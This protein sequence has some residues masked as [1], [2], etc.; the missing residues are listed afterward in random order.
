MINLDNISSAQK[1]NTEKNNPNARTTKAPLNPP[2]VSRGLEEE[3]RSGLRHR[4]ASTTFCLN[5]KSTNPPSWAFN[6]LLR[7]RNRV[8]SSEI[9]QLDEGQARQCQQSIPSGVVF[10][11]CF[12]WQSQTSAE[13][14]VKIL[15]NSKITTTN[16][17][18][19]FPYST[20]QGTV[21]LFIAQN[22]VVLKYC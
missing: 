4:D 20:F 6:I 15:C 8:A 11:F 13:A 18:Q 17:L 9:Y 5:H 1:I 16:F 19:I 21:L 3:S 2:R 14:Q 10:N 22:R 12:L 7:R